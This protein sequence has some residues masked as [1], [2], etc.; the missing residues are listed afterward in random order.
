MRHE[1]IQFILSGGRDIFLGLEEP[2]RRL[3]DN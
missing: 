2:Y 3:K 1:S